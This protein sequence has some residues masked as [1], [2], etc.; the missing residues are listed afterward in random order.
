MMIEGASRSTR[1]STAAITPATDAPIKT[2]RNAPARRTPR[3]AASSPIARAATTET[4][5]R[6]APA[7]TKCQLPPGSTAVLPRNGWRRLP[8]RTRRTAKSQ[9]FK[10]P[11]RGELA[12]RE[13]R[14]KGRQQGQ[15]READGAKRGNH[16]AAET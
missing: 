5:T 9:T 4:P 2:A 3:A 13:P 11:P 16:G 15:H 6:A 10:S 1:T 7:R 12:D 8:Q 14:D